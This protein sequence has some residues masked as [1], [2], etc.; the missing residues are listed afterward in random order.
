MSGRSNTEKILLI[1]DLD[2]TLIHGTYTELDRQA[3]F[4]VGDIHV[5]KRPFLHEFLSGCAEYFTLAIWS[6]ASD[7]YVREIAR[8]IAIQDTD[9][10]FV[11]GRSRATLPRRVDPN[12]GM[13][14][15]YSPD[16]V[17]EKPLSK[18]ARK[19]WK[20]ERILIVD[21]TP[22]KARRNYGNAIY[23]KPFEGDLSDNEL[24]KLL[25]YLKSLKDSKNVR[26]VEKRFWRSEL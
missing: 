23:P 21:D 24:P 17:Y 2:E 15:F 20:L 26:R 12:T 9:W 18:V 25:E 4:M 1:L 6:S 19:G 13:S 16:S 3:E 22:Q 10:A 14:T 5:Y 11:W 8:E 7:N